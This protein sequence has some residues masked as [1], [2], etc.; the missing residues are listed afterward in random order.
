V[1]IAWLY[2]IEELTQQQIADRLHLPRVK[3]TRLLKEARDE[4]I[5]EFHIAKPTAHL[6]LERN[7]RQHF[8]LKD[9]WIIPTP[10]Q[11]ERLRPALGEAAAEYLKPRFQPGLVVGLGMGRTLA[12]IPGSIEPH[13]QSECVFVEMV[14]GAGGSELGFDTYNVSWRLAERCGGV[15]EHVFTPVVVDSAQAREALLQDPQITATLERA[16][17][18]DVALV[19]IG[20]TGEDMLLFHL[21]HCD[22]DTVR[23][24]RARG[25]VGDILGHFFDR[26]GR[27][28]ACEVDQRIIALSLDQLRAMP[29]VVAVA[30]GSEKTEAVLGALRGAYANVLVTDAETAQTVLES[31][32]R[33]G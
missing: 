8:D 15:A 31:A 20:G 1:R 5:V 32:M 17:R 14:G 22:D 16:A 29:T 33:G 12:E 18:C 27:P 28:V 4:G 13:A 10:L 2:Y 24:L 30:G 3:V 21:G 9:A 23:D 19:G 7:L 11:R 6:K 26:D 25:A